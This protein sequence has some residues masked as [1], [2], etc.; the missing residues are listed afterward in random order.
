MKKLRKNNVGVIPACL[1]QDQ[2]C[3][4]AARTQWRDSSALKIEKINSLQ[5]Q[6]HT[7]KWFTWPE[8]D[9]VQGPSRFA[10]RGA[11]SPSKVWTV[12]HTDWWREVMLYPPLKTQQNISQPNVP[13]TE[14]QH[15]CNVSAAWPP[16][17][18]TV[19]LLRGSSGGEWGGQRCRGWH[20]FLPE[21]KEVSLPNNVPMMANRL[22]TG[23]HWT[24]KSWDKRAT[25]HKCK[26]IQCRWCFTLSGH[27]IG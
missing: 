11:G 21:N 27:F 6:K 1:R 20:A 3:R 18:H 14:W 23:F 12:W 7:R 13:P 5:L 25:G 9:L 26:D 17:Q 16:A 8:T 19:S 2:Y 4:W 24:H 22:D 15:V 10:G